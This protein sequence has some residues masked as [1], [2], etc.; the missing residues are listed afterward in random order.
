MPGFELGI[1]VRALPGRRLYPGECAVNPLKR[2]I[3]VFPVHRIAI[4]RNPLACKALLQTLV[5]V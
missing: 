3:V 1:A 2:F 4:T 5:T